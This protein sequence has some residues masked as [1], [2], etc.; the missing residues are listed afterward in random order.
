MRP[1]PIRRLRELPRVVATLGAA[2]SLLGAS[3]LAVLV[4]RSISGI[5]AE[6]YGRKDFLTAMMLLVVGV[7]VL[8]TGLIGEVVAR[9]AAGWSRSGPK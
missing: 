8:V 4:L 1:S 6:L 5:D 9:V 2:C 7:Q 3:L